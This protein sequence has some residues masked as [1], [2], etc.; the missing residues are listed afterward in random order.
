MQLFVCI[1]W[2]FTQTSYQAA[3]SDSDHGDEDERDSVS[4][5]TGSC[6]EGGRR[7]V[8][9]CLAPPDSLQSRM[10]SSEEGGS[11]PESDQ[12][13]PAVAVERQSSDGR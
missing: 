2:C 9:G 3:F 4:S 5:S 11:P 13:E 8:E 12:T 1:C 6:E 10:R 7:E